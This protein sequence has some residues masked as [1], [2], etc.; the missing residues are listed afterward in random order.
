MNP[1]S[2]PTQRLHAPATA[3]RVAGGPAAGAQDGEP[4]QDLPSLA[5]ILARYREHGTAATWDPLK[6][7]PLPAQPP[8]ANAAPNGARFATRPSPQPGT[9]RSTRHGLKPEAGSSAGP[10]R[11]FAEVIEGLQTRELN[12]GDLFEQFFGQSAP[13]MPGSK[14]LVKR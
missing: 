2:R 1:H 4:M 5:N 8:A 12:G 7:Q 13:P 10:P 3:R 11:P 6:T 14:P 9:E